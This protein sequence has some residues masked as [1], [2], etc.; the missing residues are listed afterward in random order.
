M[1]LQHRFQ[2]GKMNFLPQNTNRVCLTSQT[3]IL[4]NLSFRTP[5]DMILS[6]VRDQKKKIQHYDLIAALKIVCSKI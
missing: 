3:I 5:L 4:P 6:S 2:F 1:L